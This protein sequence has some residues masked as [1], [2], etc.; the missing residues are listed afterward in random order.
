MLLNK[1]FKI[2][3]L[4]IAFYFTR[5]SRKLASD[6]SQTALLSILSFFLYLEL[7]VHDT[8]IATSDTVITYLY[9]L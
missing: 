6:F 2:T 5:S 8:V 7:H 1:L 9:V 4:L 3:C